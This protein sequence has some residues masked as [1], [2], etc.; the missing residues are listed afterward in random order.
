MSEAQEIAPGVAFLTTAI[1]NVYFVDGPD[2]SWTLVDTGLPHCDGMVKSAA[3]KRY[4]DTPPTAIVLTHGHFDHAGSSLVLADEWNAP[5]Y[6]HRLELPYLTGRS[7]YPPQDPTIGGAIS[8]LSR[9]FTTAGID[10]G[11][12]INELPP[13]GEVPGLPDWVWHVT[14]GHAPGHVSLFRPGDKTLLAG[15]AFATVN[16]D[17]FADFTLRKQNISRPPAPFNYDWRAAHAS[18]QRLAGLQPLVVGAGH[19]TPMTGRT[20]TEEIRSLAAAF[21]IPPHGRYVAEP[22]Q[23]DDRGVIYLPPPVPD[24]LPLKLAAGLGIAALAGT[25]LSIVRRRQSQPGDNS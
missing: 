21:P 24:P 9:F 7:D 3:H 25:V 19:G 17:S 15:D 6:A 23:A 16:M 22:A 8:F 11:G 12:R 18:V 5:V 1:V 13:D 20:V 4:G 2:G 14:P 10:L